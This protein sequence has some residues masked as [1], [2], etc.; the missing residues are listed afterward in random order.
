MTA[1]APPFPDML[2]AIEAE[3]RLALDPFPPP[4]YASV[5]EMISYHLGWDGEDRPPRGKRL[6]P[7]LTVLC[8]AA[9]GGVWERALPA[10][11]A[12]ELIHNFSLVHDDIQDQSATRRGRLTL[13]KRWGTAQAINTGDAMFVLAHQAVSRL[14]SRQVD[15]TTALAVHE[16]LDHACLRLTHGQHLDLAFEAA[17][18]VS[19]AAYLEMISG[20]TAALLDAACASGALVAG[21]RPEVVDLYGAFGQHLGLAFQILDDILGIWGEPDVT[22]KPA[23]D[24]LISRKKSLPVLMGLESSPEF[25]ALWESAGGRP[26]GWQQMRKVLETAGVLE[27]SRDVAESNTRLA[28]AALEAASPAEPAG[29][30]LRLL[31][32]ILL[33]R[34]H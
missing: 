23:G 5:A 20:K 18:D 31:A 19:Q 14:R 26:Q 10:A 21:A 33:Q 16:R 3:L 29:S 13:W 4:W 24:D 2:P 27:R 34:R 22:G 7:L 11:A 8:C 17:D 25:H 32:D 15:P 28:Q 30:E 6:R 1:G 9:A 12:I